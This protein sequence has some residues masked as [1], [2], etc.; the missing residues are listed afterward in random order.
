[1]TGTDGD[2]VCEP[3]TKSASADDIREQGRRTCHENTESDEQLVCRSEGTSDLWRCSF[4]LVLQ[5][6]PLSTGIYEWKKGVAHH[7]Y[8]SAQCADSETT[9][10]TADSE[11]WPRSN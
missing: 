7:R 10:E 4:G 8:C 1:M 2:T 5:V 11:L 6:K 3:C 9:D